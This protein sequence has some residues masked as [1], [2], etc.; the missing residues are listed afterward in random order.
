[1]TEQMSF[2]APP[3]Q[4]LNLPQFEKRNIDVKVL[5]LDLMHPHLGGNKWF[6]LKEN[7]ILARQQ[8]HSTLL[9]FGGAWS[10]HIRALACAAEAEGFQSIGM[11]RGELVEPLNPVL[12]YA[13]EQ[14]MQL[15]SLDRTAYR[16]RTEPPFIAELH[17]RF[18]DF[19]L[20][21]E[22]GS[23]T[24]GVQGCTEIADFLPW[25]EADKPASQRFVLLACGTGT[26]LAGLLMGMAQRDI[27]AT[28]VGVAVLKGADFIAE[29]VR[30]WL[31]A[32]GPEL[33]PPWQ[34]ELDFHEGGY[35]RSNTSLES[36]IADFRQQTR[37][38]LEPV[39]S[40]KLFKAV[41]SMVKLGRFPPGS[42]LVII[43][44]GGILP[45]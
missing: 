25:K 5:R 22:G 7:L 21:P 15:H 40:G 17:E 2:P 45:Q 43:H 30:Q 42:E 37:L 41:A 33:V 13:A 26:T 1:M 3:L 36:F 39:Y 23:N 11:I 28:V 16:R 12:R 38:P 19:Y 14:G 34:V 32:L 44:S 29:Q 4:A 8:Q 24:A 6:K 27:Q 35:A 31:S 18:G 10:N 9:S 20:I